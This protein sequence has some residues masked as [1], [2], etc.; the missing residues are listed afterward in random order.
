MP[1]AAAALGLEPVAVD[2]ERG[3]IEL[4]F[5]AREEWTN[6]AGNVL[7]AFVAAML[8]DTVGPAL[9]ATVGPGQ[10]Q[11]TLDLKVDFLRPLRPGRVNA[12]GR[13]LRRSG[14]VAVVEARLIGDGGEDIAIATSTA[15]VIPM[16]EAR[17]AV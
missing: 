1:P 4:A 5:A 9:L 10:F 3:T 15:R 11:E 12:R 14:D 16:G 13:I 17:A 7:G 2:P 6:P 8:Y